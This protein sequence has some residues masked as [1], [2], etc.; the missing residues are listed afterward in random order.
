MTNGDTQG[1]SQH[2][3]KVH[4]DLNVKIRDLKVLVQ[5]I[6]GKRADVL[7]ER[8]GGNTT[9]KSSLD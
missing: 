8:C 9:C 5:E 6:T 3:I 2:L 1:V 7:C 4:T